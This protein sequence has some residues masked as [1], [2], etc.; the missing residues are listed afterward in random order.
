MLH[1]LLL[2]PRLILNCINLYV[3]ANTVHDNRL[4]L[5]SP[6]PHCIRPAKQ[7]QS[8]KV[9]ENKD[10]KV[11]SL[12]VDEEGCEEEVRVEPQL[13]HVEPVQNRL[14]LDMATPPYR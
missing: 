9:V 4:T 11:L 1:L 5:K 13:E 14:H 10:N 8:K 7:G 3:L 12:G 2:H 6:S